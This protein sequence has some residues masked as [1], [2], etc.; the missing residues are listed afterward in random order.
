MSLP[1]LDR[2]IAFVSPSWAL[3]RARSRLALDTFARHF[4][5]A[6]M[7]RRTSKWKAPSTGPNAANAPA[8]HKL[9][10]RVRDLVRN[11]P[12]AASAVDIV[13]T[14]VVGSGIIPTPIEG[15][16]KAIANAN[17]LWKDWAETPACDADGLS[18]IYGLQGLVMET[19]AKSGEVL[20]RRRRRRPT[21]SLPIPLQLQVL[22]PD[23]LD[24]S[25]DALVGNRGG[26]IVGGVQFD[27]LGRR[28][29]YWLFDE[30]PG[31]SFR[32]GGSSYTSR[33]IDASEILHVF[34]RDRPGQVR[35]VPFGS[36]AVIRMRELDELEDAALVREKIAACFAAFEQDLE[37]SESDGLVDPAK[38]EDEYTIEP[39]TIRKLGAGK[40]VVFGRPPVTNDLQPMQRSQLRA[41]AKGFGITFEQLTG[42]YSQ[43]NYSSGRMGWIEASR[44]N[45][46]RRWRMFIPMLLGGRRFGG[47]SWFAGAG[48]LAGYGTLDLSSRWTPPRREMIDP[49]KETI[50]ARTAIRAGLKSLS[51]QLREL[52]YHPDEVLAEIA[53]DAKKLDA[54]G[55]MVDSDGRRPATGGA[56]AA[57]PSGA[58]SNE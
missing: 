32:F 53:D 13:R 35:G 17:A 31:E 38:E 5:G 55:I 48:E 51:E 20:V 39:G 47:W 8:L 44:L 1:P 37:P 29:G 15:S 28:E 33:F 41:I 6:S 43:V 25:K 10:D 7:A 4:E 46:D 42:D 54:L 49:A 36:S 12:W 56:P 21:D 14:N 40:T 50:A 11:N 34:W 27:A 45:D 52:G 30:H 22:E 2:A 24:E 16:A 19:V 26:R 23:F 57:A 9:R 3:R 18:D 58:T